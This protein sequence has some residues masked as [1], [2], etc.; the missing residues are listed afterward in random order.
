M[1]GNAEGK[2]VNSLRKKT[3]LLLHLTGMEVEDIFEDIFDS[4]LERDQDLYTVCF[5]K[6][7]YHFQCKE[8]FHLSTTCIDNWCQLMMNQLTSF[9][10]AFVNRQGIVIL[11]ILLTTICLK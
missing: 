3:L 8:I 1:S 11:A 7:N 5:R 10:S 9:S 6:L 2:G 4:E